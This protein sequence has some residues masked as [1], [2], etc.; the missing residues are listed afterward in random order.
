MR[1]TERLRDRVTEKHGHRD[2]ERLRE[3]EQKD[4]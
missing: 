3:K 2:T 4:R 1:E